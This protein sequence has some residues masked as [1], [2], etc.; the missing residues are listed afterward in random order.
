MVHSRKS[1]TDSPEHE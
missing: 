1:P